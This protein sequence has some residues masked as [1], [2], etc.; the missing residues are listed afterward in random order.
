MNLTRVISTFFDD[1]LSRV[2]KVYK[3]GK[4]VH[5]AKQAAPFGVDSNPIANM[6]AVH[7]ATTVDGRPVIIGY[8]DKNLIADVGEIRIF[9]TNEDGDV[10]TFIHLKNN[11]QIVLGGESD[12]AVRYSELDDGLQ[13]FEGDINAEFVKIQTAITGLGGVYSR[14]NV[15]VNITDA[16]IDEIQTP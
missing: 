9:S 5:S 1:A 8:V 14:L 2:V 7:A 12:N 11:G 4:N 6:V 16:K 3:S 13:E 15:S 10:E